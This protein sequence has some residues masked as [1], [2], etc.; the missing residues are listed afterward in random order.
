MLQFFARRV[1][2]IIISMMG[3]TLVIFTLSRMAQDPRELF[4]PDS[5]YGISPQAWE[6]IGN[7]LGFDKPVVVQYFIWIGKLFR[8]DFGESLSLQTPVRD[9]IW[10]RIG[11]TIQLAVGGWIFAILL[12]VPIGV[13]AATRRGTFW[14]YIARGFALFGQALPQFFIGIILILIFAVT[15][16]WLPVG[17]RGE[18][19]FSIQYYILPSVTLGWLPA[20]GIMRLTRSAML[21]ILDSEYIKLARAKGVSSWNVIWKHALRNSL[22]PPLTSALL[23]MA[24]FLNGAVVVESIFAWPGVGWIALFRA[25]YDNDFPLLLGAVFVFIAIYLVF[26]LMADILYALIDPRIRY[27]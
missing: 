19:G 9:V 1:I 22:I 17:T 5:G 18:G 13:L 4:V 26:A 2:F 8:G 27:S 21:E 6:K 16:Q 25:V 11:A 14:D 10:S 24:G 20:A 23:L 7:E 15:L 3:A 12:G